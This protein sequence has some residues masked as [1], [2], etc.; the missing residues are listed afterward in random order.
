[1]VPEAIGHLLTLGLKADEAE[2]Y[3][4][5]LSS[6]P[7]PPDRLADDTGRDPGEVRRVLAVLA[8]IGL[9]G[10]V[11][12]PGSPMSALRPEPVLE[13]LARQREAELAGAR[14]AMTRLYEQYRRPAASY[15]ADPMVEVVSGT[16]AAERVRQLERSARAEVRG[17]DSPPYYADADANEIELENLARGVRYRAV[18]GRLALERPEYVEANILPCGKSGEEARVLPE[19]PVKLLIVDDCAALS[20]ADRTVL[21]IRSCGLFDALAGLF[22]MCW[23]VALPLGLAADASGPEI[24]PSER[25]L[26]ALLA[27]GLTDDQVARVLGVSR[28]TMFRYLENLM[29]R[30]GAANRF[31]LAL[32]ATRNDWLS[33]DHQP[34]AS[35][36]RSVPL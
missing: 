15:A 6:G 12:G 7:V 16:A 19:V 5:L 8:G 24:R 13:V 1:M 20:G 28:R 21:L 32:H 27:A 29:A 36:V 11:D 22:D 35:A 9:A 14:A 10:P 17:L 18:Y 31:Q 30:T 34:G 25:R 4:D 33:V 2:I 23:Q 26:L 3:L